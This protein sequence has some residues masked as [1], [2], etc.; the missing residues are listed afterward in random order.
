MTHVREAID[1]INRAK[2]VETAI[3]LAEQARYDAD[4]IA[5]TKAEAQRLRG[6][7]R[8]DTYGDLAYV[9]GELREHFALAALGEKWI[10]IDIRPSKAER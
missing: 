7:V 8:I 1:N 2:A 4:P 3:R 5:F 10:H 9:D 6:L